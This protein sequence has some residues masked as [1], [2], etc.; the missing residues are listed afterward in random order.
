MKK[1][2]ALSLSIL[3]VLLTFVSCGEQPV[4]ST[5]P[6]S[7]E[8]TSSTNKSTLEQVSVTFSKFESGIMEYS[9]A[10]KFSL[11]KDDAYQSMTEEYL[12][13]PAG[14]ELSS[15]KE[16][17]VYCY[18]DSFKLDTTLM[19]N[20]GLTV[21][22]YNPTFKAGKLI[23]TK[24]SIVRISVK[25]KLSDVKIEVSPSRKDLVAIGPEETI[26]CHAEIKSVGDFL[27]QGTKNVNYIYLTDIHYGSEVSDKNSD[28]QRD[29]DSTE[30]VAAK[31][32]KLKVYIEKVVTVA[33]NSD[34]IDFIV[35]GGDIV[36][37]Y[38]TPDSNDYKANKKNNPNLTV[39]KHLII[40]HQ[41]ILEPLK[42]S[43]KPVF[44]TAGNHDDNNG[45]SIYYG[46]KK[47][48][49]LLSDLDW[50]KGVFS[51]FIN[52]NVKRDSEYSYN[53]K[54]IS[55]YYYYDLKK[56]GKTTRLIFLDFNDD[57][58]TFDANGEATAQP[59]WGGYHEGQIKWLA[60]VAL[61]GK[62]DECIVFSHQ[63]YINSEGSGIGKDG[64]PAL[65][66]LLNA[67]QNKTRMKQPTFTVDF[68][69]RTSGDILLY[70]NG[71]NHKSEFKFDYNTS[72]WQIDT[73]MMV[74]RIDVVSVASEKILVKKF[75]GNTITTLLKNGSKSETT[76]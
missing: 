43:K 58:L 44:I 51:K 67:Y 29:Y 10:T 17:V 33:N 12:S 23:F 31:L 59:N 61:Q 20:A 28:G 6:S 64:N 39:A 54:S 35:V 1:L 47:V 69:G 60:T 53:G 45:H 42:D 71:H 32:A 65:E 34:D 37:G 7:S 72:F 19:Q 50:D 3:L 26:A 13:I 56:A 25:G 63:G 48:E 36:N 15:D 5:P 11:K 27:T 62:F 75:E 9:S 74:T 24:T 21:E 55:K 4:E 52:V 57:R 76:Q 41:Q 70:Q 2:V 30:E 68:A 66:N 16:F 8:Q 40:Q 46:S 22:N 49:W 38:E 73:P 14:T 18:D